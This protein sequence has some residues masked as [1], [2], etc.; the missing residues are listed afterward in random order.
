VNILSYI[1]TRDDLFPLHARMTLPNGNAG[2]HDR[3][4]GHRAQSVF[5]KGVWSWP[6]S[7]QGC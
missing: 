2:L 3:V 5:E 6:T 4:L 7:Q 1:H